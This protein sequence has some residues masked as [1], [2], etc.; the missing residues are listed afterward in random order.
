MVVKGKYLFSPMP[1]YGYACF[2]CTCYNDDKLDLRD[3]HVAVRIT[4]L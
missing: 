4:S 2:G 1:L 3:S